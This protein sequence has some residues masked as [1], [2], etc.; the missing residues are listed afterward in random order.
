LVKQ[1]VQVEVVVH[2]AVLEK[3]VVLLHHLQFK[4]LLVVLVQHLHQRLLEAVEV[5]ALLV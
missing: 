1:A 3:Q 4:V 2:Q 5:L